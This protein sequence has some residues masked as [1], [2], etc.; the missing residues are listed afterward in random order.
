MPVLEEG[1]MKR[2]HD[3]FVKYYPMLLSFKENFGHLRIPGEDPKNEFPG[4]QG[5]LKNTRSA[6]SKYKKTMKVDLLM[7]RSIT[8][9]WCQRG[10][11][12]V[13]PPLPYEKC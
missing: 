13:V 8:G 5:W 6:M 3:S 4:L 10:L 1:N 7:N 12:F 2:F 9:C 11:G